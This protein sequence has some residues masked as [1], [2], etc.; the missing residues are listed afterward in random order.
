MRDIALVAFAEHGYPDC[1]SALPAGFVVQER[2]FVHDRHSGGTLSD[3]VNFTVLH[4]DDIFVAAAPN[5]AV[6][7]LVVGSDNGSYLV[8]LPYAQSQ[9]GFFQLNV[10]NVSG[11][12][13]GKHTG[14]ERIVGKLYEEEV[15]ILV[16][17]IQVLGYIP[18]HFGYAS[19]LSSY[20]NSV[21]CQHLKGSVFVF[22]GYKAGKN[23]RRILIVIDVH[24]HIGMY[25]ILFVVSFNLGTILDF[26]QHGALVVYSE[27]EGIGVVGHYSVLV[28]HVSRNGSRVLRVVGKRKFAGREQQLVIEI[29]VLFETVSVVKERGTSEPRLSHVFKGFL[30]DDFSRHLVGNGEVHL[31]AAANHVHINLIQREKSVLVISESRFF[32][33]GVDCLFV[34]GQRVGVHTERKQISV[35]LAFFVEE[36][37]KRGKRSGGINQSLHF[38]F[39]QHRRVVCRLFHF[40]V[41]FPEHFLVKPASVESEVRYRQIYAALSGKQFHEAFHIHSVFKIVF[42]IFYFVF[43][44]SDCHLELCGLTCGDRNRVGGIVVRA[45]CHTDLYLAVGEHIRLFK[46]RPNLVVPDV[47]ALLG[48]YLGVERVVKRSGSDIYHVEVKLVFARALGVVV[49]R[50]LGVIAVVHRQVSL[51]RE[52]A[53]KVGKSR[54]LLAGRIRIALFVVSDCSRAHDELLSHRPQLRRRDVGIFFLQILSHKQNDA[55][56]VGR[57]HTGSALNGVLV[58]TRNGR[59][60]VAAVCGDIRFERQAGQRSP[61]AEIGHERTCEVGSV[62]LHGS[63]LATCKN[64]AHF[65]VYRAGCDV[66]VFTYGHSYHTRRVVVNNYTCR[67]RSVCRRRLFFKAGSTALDKSN[68]AADVYS[69]APQRVIVRRI[70]YAGYGHIFKHSALLFAEEHVEEIVLYALRVD[71]IVKV[72]RSF[73]VG[74]YVRSLDAAYRRNGERGIIAARA[75]Y[76]TRVGVACQSGAAVGAVHIGVVFVARRNAKGN[77]R[78]SDGIE[79]AVDDAGLSAGRKTGGRTQAHV[80]CVNA[81]SNAVL[82][83]GKY[84][85]L[86]G[87]GVLLAENLHGGELR[88]GSNAGNHVGFSQYNA[89]NV[90]AVRVAA[91]ISVGVVVGIVESIRDF[92][93]VI[94]VVNAQSVVNGAG[95]ELAGRKHRGDVLPVHCHCFRVGLMLKS[96]VHSVNTRVEHGNHHAF[97]RVAGAGA[98]ENTGRFI[99]I[100]KVFRNVYRRL[101]VKLGNDDVLDVVIRLYLGNISVS[102]VCGKS[103]HD[104]CII[105]FELNCDARFQQ[106]CHKSSLLCF[107]HGSQTF[108]RRALQ[109]FVDGRIFFVFSLVVSGNERIV[110][111]LHNNPYL[112]LR[113]KYGRLVSRQ[114]G[115]VGRGEH[116]VRVESVRNQAGFVLVRNVGYGDAVVETGAASRRPCVFRCV[117]SCIESGH[118]RRNGGGAHHQHDQQQGQ[119]FFVSH[120]GT[121]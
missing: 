63:R 47:G 95:F 34:V 64:V 94:N 102:D 118:V 14:V 91:G 69:A 3:G 58:V 25:G 33:V 100:D 39:V 1:G 2:V 106:L 71:R 27:I 49:K 90:N 38:V 36:R 35:P 107:K 50:Q 52:R 80:D 97:S 86:I 31:F 70:A 24:I 42:E 74:D 115:D 56:E 120:C 53:V 32:G 55:C 76:C 89:G 113:R 81:Q 66:E 57:S 99:H 13:N 28:V 37:F 18:G 96:L 79:Y 44:K 7:P 88:L 111:K 16:G 23:R 117:V 75:A 114:F 78:F 8:Q 30:V 77:T 9:L 21:A 121:S 62:D 19:P 73:A 93:A 105:V 10:C 12:R 87:A 61:G 20:G 46:N 40:V 11:Q 112:V 59:Q 110:R 45:V 103:V 4:L 72:S 60:N 15:V 119:H 17:I 85:H 6:R 68:L 98:V 109:I 22:S 108:C 116:C 92:V 51:R 41:V 83:S 48:H 43:G 65:L 67:A 5:K 26:R 84:V 82:D 101:G 29:D 104:R 54:A